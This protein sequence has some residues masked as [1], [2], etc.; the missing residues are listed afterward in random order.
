MQGQGVY[1]LDEPEA[2]LS[3]RKQAELLVFLSAIQ[4]DGSAQVVMATH[5]PILMAVPGATLLKLTHRGIEESELRDTDHFRLWSAFASD[6]DGFVAA[7][8]TDD[9]DNLI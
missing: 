5:S 9:L 7:A 4:K 1:F 8:L 6:P 3:P 2:A